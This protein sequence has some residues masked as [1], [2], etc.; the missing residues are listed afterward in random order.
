MHYTPEYPLMDIGGF[1][2]KKV[3]SKSADR[4][5][6][7]F[8]IKVLLSTVASLLLFSFLF[9]EII[10]RLDLSL[11]SAKVFS[12]IICGLTSVFVSLISVY[13]NKN[14][15]AILGVLSVIP[16]LLYTLFN[17]IFNDTNIILFLIKVVLIVLCGALTGFLISNKTK[18]FKV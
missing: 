6:I 12:L 18:K 13:G 10:Y 5:I 9:S 4:V 3:S 14:K 11:D 16:L 7:L 1:V 2:M 17:L 8:I 15:G